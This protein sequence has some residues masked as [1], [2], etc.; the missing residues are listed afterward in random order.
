M[1]EPRLDWTTLGLD[2][3]APASRRTLI[4]AS[5][6]TGKTWTISVLY[7]RL[8]TERECRATQIVVTTFTD[9][10][11]QELRERIRS[12]LQWAQALASAGS[13]PT[14]DAEDDPEVRAWLRQ[15][16]LHE[17]SA[18]DRDA[19]R[20]RLALSELDL[21]PIGTIHGLCRKILADQPFASGSAF[22]IGEWVAEEDLVRELVEDLV[23]V[24]AHEAGGD[25]VDRM[26]VAAFL[27]AKDK[28]RREVQQVVKLA[29]SAA[30]TVV[31]PDFA[32]LR[33]DLAAMA[34]HAAALS[35][36]AARTD[37]RKKQGSG[38][39]ETYLA[40]LAAAP[41]DP[42][43]LR[44][45]IDGFEV[46]IKAPKSYVDKA[47]VAEF[48]ASAAFQAAKSLATRHRS[49]ANC[50]HVAAVAVHLEQL[51][52]WRD[53]RL[54]ERN[55]FTFDELIE[56]VHQGTTSEN[57]GRA[58]A[59]RLFAQ[60]PVAL[61]DEFQDTD[62][63]QF[64]IFDAIY[65]D[66]C[67]VP[68]GQLVMIGDP[69]Q[70]IYGFRGGDIHA[71]LGAAARATQ[72]MSLTRNFR[73][74]SGVIEALNALYDASSRPFGMADGAIA[75]DTVTPAGGADEKPLDAPALLAGAAL[76]LHVLD[77]AEAAGA[78]EKAEA[79]AMADC[80][81]RV[82]DYLRPG[83]ATIGGEA[84]QPKH[85]AILLPKR[86][87]IGEMRDL[88]AARGVPCVGA[89]NDSIFETAW[90]Q[91]LRVVLHALLHVTDPGAIRA[92][93]ATRLI[94]RSLAEIQ[95]MSADLA[96]WSRELEWFARGALAWREHGVL[97][98]I[99]VLI[100]AAAPRLLAQPDGER[101]LTDLRH[102]GELLQTQSRKRSGREQLLAWLADQC[103]GDV[104][105]DEQ[106]GKERE[107]RIESD[108]KRVRIMTLH[109][110]KGLEFDIVMLPLMWKHDVVRTPP[111]FAA[112]SR[113]T[114]PGRIIDLGGPDFDAHV[115]GLALEQKQ[116]RLRVLYVAL[117]RARHACHLTLPPDVRPGKGGAQG[118]AM[119]V[120]PPKVNASGIAHFLHG[121]DLVKLT[122]DCAAIRHVRAHPPRMQA[123]AP[124]AI[125]TTAREARA[126][127]RRLPFV[128]SH[129][130]S[131][132]TRPRAASA[133]DEDG[134]AN[135]ERNAIDD[136]N[137][138]PERG[139]AAG[140][141]TA[142]AALKALA[143]LRG[144]A[145]G[146]AVH[147]IYEHRDHGSEVR[148][149][150]PFVQWQL[151]LAGV[152]LPEDADVVASNLGT[153]IDATLATD[154]GDGLRLRDLAPQGQRAEM[155]FHIALSVLQLDAFEAVCIRHGHAELMP[156][157]VQRRE[158]RGFLTGKIDLVLEHGGRVH[159]LD[160]KSNWL[161]DALED[162]AGAAL[163]AAML[164]HGYPF[165]ALLY[166]IA[167][168]RYL[169]QRKADYRRERHLGDAIYLFVR[170]V[171]LA[172]GIGLWRHRFAP[173]LIADLDALFDVEVAEAVA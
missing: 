120:D 143:G 106:S 18:Q 92:A 48:E 127:S 134:A 23:R 80:A 119:A 62:A 128:G 84:V 56:Q 40:D 63:R 162:Y 3:G 148:H 5:A 154:L 10:A 87:Y 33:A 146:N 155:A 121:V 68:R 157:A 30:N 16:W 65:G 103:D 50:L 142:H 71:Y 60:W 1:T 91:D 53:Q 160:Y 123:S 15:R 45:A 46:I 21:A 105:G 19:L 152:R 108:E 25:V 77:D 161:G 98:A 69:K 153:R 4:E 61:I 93:M 88:L 82:Q 100:E 42:E 144:A 109:A 163:D 58:L 49:L 141:R 131:T 118:D 31:A 47:G 90:A 168:D 29:L 17:A 73:S 75:Y 111:K 126:F 151:A 140:V 54:Q 14:A 138:N 27:A 12:R 85:I 137:D 125:E 136:A 114:S 35:A 11:A 129:S 9:P 57:A 20:L 26:V 76:Q 70:A 2:A 156:S 59:D 167:V 164:A 173:A 130:F 170:A 83:A 104:D 135:D 115:D 72:R 113:P 165:Q 132:L 99:D 172:P 96:S 55:Q 74:S 133:L 159:L 122:A 32:A 169:R 7:L 51:R 28:G 66:A 6:G 34:A 117:T 101:A 78:G 112:R 149:Q 116:E 94:G 97:K 41:H 36:L 107:L 166:V 44:R 22:R 79:R 95:A 39:L 147:A 110:S 86:R 124:V 145:F 13:P 67:G 38:R 8:V 81:D 64:G 150:L 24:C 37:W 171:G 89:G 102:L 158:L 52:T 43:A 139:E